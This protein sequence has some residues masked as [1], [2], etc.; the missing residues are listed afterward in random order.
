MIDKESEG[1]MRPTASLVTGGAGFIGSHVAEC[2]VRMG[3]RVVVLDDLSGGYRENV[4][5]KAYFVEGSILDHALVDSLFQEHRFDHVYH[6]AAY[7]AEGLSHFIKR[8]NY[9]NN[10]IGSVNLINAAVNYCARTF[11]FTSSIAV[12][13][14]GQ[15]P[16]TEDMIPIPEDSYGIAKLAIEQELRVCREMFGLNYVVFRPHNV[17]GERQN[18]GDRYRNV[19]GIFM[20]QLLK[21]EPMTI[22]GDGEQSRA[23]THIN[24][25]APIIAASVNQ[26]AAHNQVFNV[27]ADVPFTVNHLAKVVATAMG[28]ECKVRYLDSRNE[29]KHAFSDH[30]KV[31]HIFGNQPR[32]S[33][34]DGIRA[35]VK[36]VTLHGARESG[37]FTGIEIASK[38]PPSWAMATGEGT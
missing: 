4:P 17:Y 33:L 37:V 32:T 21:G 35:M 36:W 7:A 13:G 10:V 18:I 26:P 14:A 11:V 25:V 3:H 34:E 28:K 6:L 1:T 8:F 29:V 5:A 9:N 31:E 23:F 24:D 30:A 38:L 27:G 2:L 19:V 20:N 22:F 15:T 16:M 12:Y